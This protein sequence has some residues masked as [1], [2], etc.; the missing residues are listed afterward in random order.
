[1]SNK[2]PIRHPH[3]GFEIPIV[4]TWR[5]AVRYEKAYAVSTRGR[6]K[7]VERRAKIGGGRTR[8]VC[9]RFL[10]AGLTGNYEIVNLSLRGKQKMHLVH[11][12][13][14]EAFVGPCPDGMECCHEDGNPTNNRLENL[15][16]GTPKDNSNDDA[17]NGTR[18]RMRGEKHYAAKLTEAE[19]LEIRQMYATGRYKQKDLAKKF[20]RTYILIHNIVRRKAWTHI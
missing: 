12:L 18:D 5:D 2:N 9:E 10:K 15:R 19:V 6:V 1:M 16:W 8:R 17:K 13:V 3:Y 20:K 11:R 14:L 4:E 7:T